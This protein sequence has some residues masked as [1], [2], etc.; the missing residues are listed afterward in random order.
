MEDPHTPGEGSGDG[1]PP[2]VLDAVSPGD[3]R[4]SRTAKTN[5]IIGNGY[6][7]PAVMLMLC[8]LLQLTEKPLA[9]RVPTPLQLQAETTLQTRIRGTVFDQRYLSSSPH[10]RP[11]SEIATDT[12]RLLGDIPIPQRLVQ[13]TVEALSSIEMDS[14]QSFWVFLCERGHTHEEAPPDWAAQK[15]RG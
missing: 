3:G 2:S 6:H 1:V 8:I 15:S 7:I 14:L 11:T 4:A 9:L 13:T 5:S 12:L 10:L